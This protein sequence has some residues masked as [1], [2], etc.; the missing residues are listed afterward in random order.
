M[1]IRSLTKHL[2]LHQK[3]EIKWLGLGQQSIR[4]LVVDDE[5]PAIIRLK[6]LLKAYTDI[7]VVCESHDGLAALSDIEEK[8]PDLVFLD[9]DSQPEQR[10]YLLPAFD[11]LFRK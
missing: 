5:I 1:P 2:N 10:K 3:N 11:F 4:A 6:T 9:I 8:K 7:D